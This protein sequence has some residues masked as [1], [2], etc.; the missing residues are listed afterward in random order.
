MLWSWCGCR[1]TRSSDHLTPRWRAGH[2][3]PRNWGWRHRAW[4][5]SHFP[6]WRHGRESRAQTAKR[7]HEW[8][9]GQRQS[10][11]ALGRQT[12]SGH[13]VTARLAGWRYATTTTGRAG[14]GCCSP[15][16]SQSLDMVQAERTGWCAS[17]SANRP[18]GAVGNGAS[19]ALGPPRLPAAR[20]LGA[21]VGKDRWI[22]DDTT[23]DCTA[24]ICWGT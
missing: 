18:I 14:G 21:T 23:Q 13:G 5:R 3:V 24:P 12:T 8:T 20:G 17:A 19:R 16:W 10:V 11:S 7:R 1:T 2:I 15:L 6:R 22:V 9:H 4:L